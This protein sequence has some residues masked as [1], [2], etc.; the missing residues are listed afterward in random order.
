MNWRQ[1]PG[2]PGLAPARQQRPHLAAMRQRRLVR[3]PGGA[4][5]RFGIDGQFDQ[6][7]ERRRALR[8]GRVWRPG[9]QAQQGLR[10]GRL[11]R[12]DA[13]RN[14]GQCCS[15]TGTV[16]PHG[17]WPLTGAPG[18]GRHR[19]QQRAALATLTLAWPSGEVRTDAG[20]RAGKAG[21]GRRLR[22]AGWRACAREGETR[23]FKGAGV[24]RYG[25]DGRFTYRETV[26]G[27]SRRNDSWF[28]PAPARP[29]PARCC[30]KR[31]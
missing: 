21:T 16:P 8:G 12:V 24:V 22:P 30:R 5:V 27:L 17:Q 29:S 19:L 13:L 26:N 14:E 4:E 3:R 2:L 1:G 28:D 25:L 15:A 7:R 20:G 9:L 18:Q 31:R 11:G 23:S 10:G 6:A